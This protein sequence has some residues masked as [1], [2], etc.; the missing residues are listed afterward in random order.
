MKYK[1]EALT[2]IRCVWNTCWGLNTINLQLDE[3]I[4]NVHVN[5]TLSKGN[6]YKQMLLICPTQLTISS[7]DRTNTEGCSYHSGMNHLLP[8]G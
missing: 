3:S 8:I 6:E 2:R 1:D 7:P 4:G 5:L